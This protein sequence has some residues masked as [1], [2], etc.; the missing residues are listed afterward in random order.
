MESFNTLWW[1]PQSCTKAPTRF[2]SFRFSLHSVWCLNLL[3][4]TPFCWAQP[5]NIYFQEL[6]Q[7]LSNSTIRCILQDSRGFMWFGTPEGLNRYDGTRYKL[8]ENEENDSTSLCD[9][10][11]NVI[12][13]APDG[14]LWIGTANGL[15][16][17]DYKTETFHKIDVFGDRDIFNVSCLWLDLDGTLWVGT[18]GNGLYSYHPSDSAA[19]SFGKA[20]SHF[21]GD[22]VGYQSSLFIGTRSGLYQ[23]DKRERNVVK[24]EGK[25]NSATHLGDIQIQA[26]AANQQGQLWIGTYGEGLYQLDLTGEKQGFKHFGASSDPDSL[27]HNTI[28]SLLVD[29][30]GLWIGTENGGLNYLNTTTNSFTRY[31]HVEGKPGTLSD[32]SIW[33]IAKNSSGIFYSKDF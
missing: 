23:L 26:I 10:V 1:P 15:A 29:H 12:T 28:L 27:S 9:N 20:T 22:I 31:Q 33:S 16:K 13:E 17:F 3:L 7:G 32:N 8:F 5:G 14:S 25:K 18:S 30:D 11:V 4:L 6:N 21:I 19:H 2:S 24:V